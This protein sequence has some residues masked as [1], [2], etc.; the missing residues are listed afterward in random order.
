MLEHLLEYARTR[1]L[2]IEPGFAPKDVRWAIVCNPEG[3]LADVIELGDIDAKRNPGQR[4]PMCPNLTQPEFKRGGTGTRPLLVDTLAVLALHSNVDGREMEKLVSK[5]DF[6]VDLLRRGA[7]YCRPLDAA[8]TCLS[9]DDALERIRARLTDSRA[10]PTDKATLAIIGA[11]P[12]YPVESHEWHGFWQEFRA[13]LQADSVAG[14]MRCFSSGEM[15]IPTR[16]HQKIKGLTDVGGLP[17][18]DTLVCFDKSAFESYGLAQSANCAVEENDA[19]VYGTALNDLVE[20]AEWMPGI[21]LA[22]W[23]KEAIQ[24]EDD[25]LRWLDESDDAA[26]GAAEERARKLVRAVR[27]GERPDLIRNRYFAVTL[28]GASGRVMVR[29]WLDGSFTKLAAS[30]SQWFGDISIVD[31][32]GERVQ[33]ALPLRRLLDSLLPHRAKKKEKWKRLPPYGAKEKE[34]KKWKSLPPSVAHRLWRAAVTMRPIPREVLLR[35]HR[36]VRLAVLRGDPMRPEGL[37]LIKAF[38]IR[39][40]DQ[41]MTATLNEDHPA[42]AYQCGRL[43]A[44]YAELQRRALP[45]VDAGV[46]QRYFAAAQTTPNLVLGRIAR[47]S[48]AHLG[49]LDVGLRRWWETRIAEVWGQIVDVPPRVLTPEQQSLFSLGYYQQIAASRARKETHE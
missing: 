29:D 17:Q 37:A 28:S 27:A 43:M 8:A 19:L 39:G 23:Y 48:Q 12:T 21:K 10:K 42:A 7:E 15:A 13:T 41:Q 18:G 11:T 16:T 31:P 46:V 30:V 32:S 14:P 3:T 24:R 5:H 38:H 2:V 6:F 34:K 25:P 22:C 9:D 4:F 49:K 35:A 40:G 36:K 26:R 45:D 44:L 20:R 47:L 1:N 33:G